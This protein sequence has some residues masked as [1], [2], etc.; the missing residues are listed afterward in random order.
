MRRIRSGREL[1]DSAESPQAGRRSVRRRKGYWIATTV[2]VAE[3]LAGGAMDLFRFHP[4]VSV[5]TGLGYPAYFATILGSAKLLAA[6]AL[7]AP[8]YPRL[9]EWAYAG[10][11]F[12]MGGAA[13]SQLAAGNTWVDAVVPTGFLAVTIAS[14][15]LRPSGRRLEAVPVHPP[16]QPR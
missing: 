8:G 11:V 4:Y 10:V 2:V 12:N 14:W 6:G 5:L 9:K 1:P 15:A 16:P 13:I 3:S 7:L